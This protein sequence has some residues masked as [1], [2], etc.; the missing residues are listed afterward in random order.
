MI[1][2]P[3]KKLLLSGNLWEA[4][5]RQ[6]SAD[7]SQKPIELFDGSITNWLLLYGLLTIWRSFVSGKDF[8]AATR[9]PLGARDKLPLDSWTFEKNSLKFIFNVRAL[10]SMYFNYAHFYWWFASVW[11]HWYFSPRFTAFVGRSG[12]FSLSP[13]DKECSETT[14]I[15]KRIEEKCENTVWQISYLSPTTRTLKAEEGEFL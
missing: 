13:R 2:N 3:N 15:T 12:R 1:R 6:L 8:T 10:V 4:L 14:Q 9:F 11:E 5:K 7:K